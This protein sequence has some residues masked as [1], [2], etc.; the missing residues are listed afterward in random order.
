MMAKRKLKF[1][2]LLL[3]N[4]WPREKIAFSTSTQNIQSVTSVLLRRSHVSILGQRLSSSEGTCGVKSIGLLGRSS[5][6]LRDQLLM[7]LQ[8]IPI[9][10]KMSSLIELVT[11]SRQGDVERWTNVGGSIP[12]GGRPIY[13][14]SAVPISRINTGG[15]VKR[16]R[17]IADSPPDLDA[18]EVEVVNNL[19]G[20]QSSTSPSHPPAR[21]FQSR[22]IPS[23]PRTFQ[24][25]LL[26]F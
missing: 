14:T 3:L 7:L 18:E 4:V 26:P 21:I 2:I 10:S 20:H 12:V 5:Q 22:L 11:G 16:I 8:D 19:V 23:T 9:V 24:P 13:F 17:R 1:L 15:V 25:L 6:F